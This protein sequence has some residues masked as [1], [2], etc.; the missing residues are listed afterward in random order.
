MDTCTGGSSGRPGR[1]QTDPLDRSAQCPSSEL[2]R[3]VALVR[4]T[5]PV[6][7]LRSAVLGSDSTRE[8]VGRLRR[9]LATQGFG[10][11][12]DS[13]RVGPD[14]REPHS[15]LGDDAVLEPYGDARGDHRP[16]TGTSLDLLVR[17]RTAG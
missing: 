4:S 11:G 3:Q 13:G 17:A 1:W 15:G 7:G 8:L 10:D 14:G 5:P 12:G 2:L 9:R 16:V 6:L